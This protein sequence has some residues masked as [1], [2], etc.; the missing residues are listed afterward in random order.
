[1]RRKDWGKTYIKSTVRR[2]KQRY[3][4]DPAVQTVSTRTSKFALFCK[5]DAN[6]PPVEVMA[7]LLRDIVAK[8]SRRLDAKT[9]LRWRL[10]SEF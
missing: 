3:D 7:S 6:S 4:D 1:V 2:S 10:A 5:R 9:R 8:A